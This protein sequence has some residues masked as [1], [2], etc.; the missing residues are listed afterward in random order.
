MSTETKQGYIEDFGGNKMIPETTSA[1]VTDLAK[2]QALSQTLLDTPDKD[3]LGYD[4]FSTVVYVPKGET[5]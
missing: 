5:V 4:A 3:A 2:N 1:M